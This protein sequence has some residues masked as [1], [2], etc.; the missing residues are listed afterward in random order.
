[1]LRSASQFRAVIRRFVRSRRGA[2][3]VEFALISMPLMILLFGVLE[4]A[5]I[6]LVSA[7]LDTATDFAARNIR[8]GVFQQGP[9]TMKGQ[10]GFRRLVCVNMSWLQQM[11]TQA[12]PKPGDPDP[13][14]L[15]VEAR[16]FDSYAAA[17]ALQRRDPNTFDPEQTDWCA[18][19]P[20]DIVVVT[21]Y[22]KWPIVTPLIRPLFK[23]YDGGRM[24]SSTRLFRNEPFNP[25]LPRLGNSTQCP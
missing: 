23:N 24:I 18:G 21:T 22:F 12:A 15:F 17:G 14:P 13:N 6:L 19:N 1:M 2:T 25:A 9:S 4:L 8:T 3:A 7:T 5:M 11:C 16:T 10:D 20:E